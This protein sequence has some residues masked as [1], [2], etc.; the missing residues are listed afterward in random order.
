[1]QYAHFSPDYIT[2]EKVLDRVFPGVEGKMVLKSSREG[3]D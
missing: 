3:T 1:M 2:Q